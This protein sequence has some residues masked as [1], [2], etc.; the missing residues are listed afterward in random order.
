MNNLAAKRNIIFRADGN[1]MLGMGHF[2]RTL[3]L[4]EMLNNN[5][6]CIFATH[7]PNDYQIKE[8][9]RVC[10]GE[11]DLPEDNSHFNV[12][13]TFLKGNEIVVLDNY[14]FTTEYQKAIKAK[15]CKL[16][17]IDDM[18]D[19]HYIADIVINHAEGMLPADFSVED[20]TKL[21]L[22]NSYALLRSPFLTPIQANLKNKYSALIIMGGAD[23]Q[24]ITQTII[25]KI[26]GADLNKPVAIV[27]NR[28]SIKTPHD[29]KTEKFQFFHKL[30]SSD[31]FQLMQLSNFGILPAST[32]AIEACAARLPFICGFFVENQYEIY[33][34][35]ESNK[36]GVCIGNFATVSS[37]AFE[38]SLRDIN[39]KNI[40][41]QIID[42]QIV[43]LDKQSDKRILKA[44]LEL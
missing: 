1:P 25:N 36:L 6:H 2:T 27:A 12:F 30:S 35:I 19:K 9:E 5:F 18:H 31:I 22:G 39:T 40:R 15:G 26:S 43:S 3:A 7:K 13:L 42:R 10:H 44:F 32:V 29:N 20:Y 4:A 14:Y 33:R 17:C 41:D 37:E 34:G 23:P 16:V 11:I 8:I 28:N 21:L 24:N 38:S